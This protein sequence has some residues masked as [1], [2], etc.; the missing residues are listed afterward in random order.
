MFLHHHPSDA[1]RERETKGSA[2]A[3]SVQLKKGGAS[4]TTC[5]GKGPKARL[6][7]A[8]ALGRKE[9]TLRFFFYLI[10]RCSASMIPVK[11]QD[12]I[13]R[14]DMTQLATAMIKNSNDDRD[15]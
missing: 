14:S 5:Q 1:Q 12:S 8:P 4:T 10:R 7:G 9:P 3:A 15:I 2:H 11:Q 6:D 13:V